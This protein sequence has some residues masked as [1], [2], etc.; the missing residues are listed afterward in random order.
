MKFRIPRQCTA[1]FSLLNMALLTFVCKF[2]TEA[3]LLT[4]DAESPGDGR[5]TFPILTQQCQGPCGS[6]TLRT[7]QGHQ[8]NQQQKK[9]KGLH[10]PGNWT[11][12][13]P[14]SGFAQH[15][16]LSQEMESVWRFPRVCHHGGPPASF[17]HGRHIVIPHICS[18]NSG[19]RC[20]SSTKCKM[21]KFTN[22]K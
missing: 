5:S 12:A 18:K 7:N 10:R 15:F 20:L 11:S 16:S 17:Y 19:A 13:E 9:R 1:D 4:S 8:K 21:I 3:D 6:T 22:V 14:L 2:A